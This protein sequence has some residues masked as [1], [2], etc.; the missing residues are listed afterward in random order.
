M[1]AFY[2]AVLASNREGEFFVTIPDLPGVNSGAAT[3]AEALALAIDFANDY[4]RD[5]VEEGHDVPAARDI[6]NIPIEP[7]DEEIGRALIPVE[8]PGKSV[9]VSISMDEAL[10]ARID[11][12]AEQVGLTRSGYIAAAAEFRIRDTAHNS[13][14]RGIEDLNRITRPVRV[15]DAPH[16]F[17]GGPEILNVDGRVFIPA[18]TV[19]Y[20]DEDALAHGSSDRHV[21][22]RPKGGHWEVIRQRAGGRK[23]Q[24]GEKAK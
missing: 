18:P 8:V 17:Y 6:D 15:T 16:V 19:Q 24:A 22:V 21:Q 12:A 10:L 2:V 1:S 13:R 3:R 5:L 23:R 20:I 9:K 7:E 11:R 4:V 14:S